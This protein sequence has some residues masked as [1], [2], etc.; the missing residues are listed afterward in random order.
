MA[1]NGVTYP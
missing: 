1:L